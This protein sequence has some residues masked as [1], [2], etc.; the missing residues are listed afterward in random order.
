MPRLA[1]RLAA[2][3]LAVLPLSAAAHPGHIADAAGH[4]HWIA[5]IAIGLAIGLSLWAGLKG[6][7]RDDE[8][9]EDAGQAEPE[10]QAA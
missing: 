4:D 6:R 5:G 10:E 3:A 2:P 1:L 8:A 7:K 9:S